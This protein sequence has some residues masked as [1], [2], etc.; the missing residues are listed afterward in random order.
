LFQL[1]GQVG[2]LRTPG[3]WC[4]RGSRSLGKWWRTMEWMMESGSEFRHSLC[5]YVIRR[6]DTLW[7]AKVWTAQ[8]LCTSSLSSLRFWFFRLLQKNSN[9]LW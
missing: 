6:C 9:I 8:G 2:R 7:K 5:H 4:S 1:G 3:T